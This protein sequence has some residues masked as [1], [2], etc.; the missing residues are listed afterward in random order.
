MDGDEALVQLDRRGIR[1]GVL[2]RFLEQLQEQLVE[3][4]ELR[5]GA[6]VLLHELFDGQVRLVTPVTETLGEFALMVE[7]QPVFA[8]PGD[9]V[10][11][12]A[13]APQQPPALEQRLELLVGEE[14]QAG[15]VFQPVGAEVA[16]RDPEHRLDVAQSARALLEV[17]LEAVGGVAELGVPALLLG[18]LGLEEVG[19]RPDAALG[20][21]GLHAL[22]Q[23]RAARQ[24]P[25]FHQVGDHGDVARGFLAALG[26]GAH[27]VADLQ[28]QVPEQADETLDPVA[29]G[30][31]GVVLDEQRQVHVGVGV[32]LAPAV[33]PDRDQGAARLLARETRRPERAQRLVDRGGAL[34]HQGFDRG[35]GLE[36]GELRALLR[37]QP[38]PV[39]AGEVVQRVSRGGRLRHGG[40]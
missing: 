16:A 8:P 23:G 15:E 7:Q 13:D 11:E 4:L 38:F 30:V 28:A 10:E 1:F 32:Q 35:A 34:A 33:A 22:E 36:G 5:D 39:P 6:E 12:E 25:R 37:R 18:E 29:Q 21:G 26:D 14:A 2:D 40:G 19:P 3:P 27:A 9:V 17:R 20:D 31:Q 24:G